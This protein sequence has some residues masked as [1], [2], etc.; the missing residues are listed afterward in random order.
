MIV[1]AGAAPTR[2]LCA[3]HLSLSSLF[4]IHTCACAGVIHGMYQFHL[5]DIS[6]TG[7]KHRTVETFFE[8]FFPI[9]CLDHCISYY[10]II[11][12]SFR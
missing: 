1:G 4:I 10:H 7:G 6:I 8:M 11:I 9:S 5:H 2:T 12:K 3:A